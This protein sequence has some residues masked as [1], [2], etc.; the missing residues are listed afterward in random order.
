MAAILSLHVYLAKHIPSILLKKQNNNNN[1]IKTH[2]KSFDLG[3]DKATKKTVLFCISSIAEQQ[4]ELLKPLNHPN[5]IKLKDILINEPI[6]AV[7]T[8]LSTKTETAIVLELNYNGCLFDFVLD[9]GSFSEA[10]ARVIFVE[11]V[12][13]LDY[14]KLQGLAH[15]DLK[16][17][18]IFFDDKYRPVIAEFGFCKRFRTKLYTVLG[19]LGYMAPE[20]FNSV[21]LGGY[22]GFSSDLFALGVILFIMVYGTPPFSK[23]DRVSDAYYKMFCENNE[24]YWNIMRNRRNKNSAC[25]PL[26]Q[27]FIDLVDRMLKEKPEDRI[28]IEEIQEHEWLKG[29]IMEKQRYFEEM[30][31]RKAKTAQM[32]EVEGIIKKLNL[33]P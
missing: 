6:K 31:E 18:I 21:S 30:N 29:E 13:C 11:L 4:A 25:E 19:T 23:A 28:T 5:I 16:P 17:D 8:G 32:K 3:F 7:S 24:K 14:F 10:L 1:N 9:T 2:L 33:N 12:D 27:S 22:D 26:S 20:I 15:R